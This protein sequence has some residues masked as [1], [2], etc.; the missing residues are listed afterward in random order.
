V[1]ERRAI[2]FLLIPRE[3]ASSAGSAGLC[4][5]IELADAPF[6]LRKGGA[7]VLFN[8]HRTL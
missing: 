3:F 5:G 2:E 1:E 7:F 4:E 8:G 6:L